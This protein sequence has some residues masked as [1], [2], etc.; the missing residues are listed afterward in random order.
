MGGISNTLT[1]PLG[2]KFFKGGPYADA[3]AGDK[4]QANLSQYQAQIAPIIAQIAKQAGVQDPLSGTNYATSTD[5]YGLSLL[6][7][8][9]VNQQ[10]S[11]DTKGYQSLLS[12][13]KANLAARG[14]GDSSTMTAAEAYLGQQLQGQIGTERVQAGQNAYQN[15]QTALQQIAQILSGQYGAQQQVTQQQGATATAARQ[16]S[17][18][19]L[20]SL[21]G[22][23]FGKGLT[24][25]RT[26]VPTT[27]S[28]TTPLMT[29]NPAAASAVGGA[30]FPSIYGF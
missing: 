5:P 29:T 17:L 13:V 8:S 16:D 4:M 6:Q 14:M 12:K 18:T 1:S 10:S 27:S 22:L 26:T 30:T 20:G 2:V 19:Q 9:E 25:D 21:L 28:S 24:K 15:R 3:G 23:V 7:Q 11:V